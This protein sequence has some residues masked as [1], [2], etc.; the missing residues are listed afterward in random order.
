MKKKPGKFLCFSRRKA[1]VFVLNNFSL[2]CGFPIYHG[3]LTTDN[4]Q[5]INFYSAFRMFAAP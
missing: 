4:Q 1:D 5:T 2:K 3:P